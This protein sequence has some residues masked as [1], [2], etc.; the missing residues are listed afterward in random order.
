MSE[1]QADFRLEIAHVLFMDIV[2]FSKSLINEQSEMLRR[3]NQIV[4]STAQVQTAE[5]AGK[6]TRLPTGDG[7][8]LAFFTTPDAPLRCA[9]EIAEGL[10]EYPTL[11]VRMGINSG[12]VDEI[13]DVNERS[14]LAGTGIN[15]A[16]RVMDCGD[17]GHILLSKRSADDLAQY[18]R[19][20]P[21][22]HELGPCEIKHGTRIDIVNFHNGEAGNAALPGKLKREEKIATIPKGKK[23]TGIVLT[24]AALLLLALGVW[25]FP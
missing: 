18:G 1:P 15:I 11:A 23:L 16:Q 20:R 22:L 3:L 13:V 7:I 8:A 14:N 9:V 2:C 6:L 24:A 21:H 12:P 25:F 19:W 5:A 10:K 4:A 17:A